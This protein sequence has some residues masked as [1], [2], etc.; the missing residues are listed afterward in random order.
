M[1]RWIRFLLLGLRSLRR[2]RLRPDEESTLTLR[3]W[4]T[5][6]DISVVNNAAYLTYFE[7]GRV[8]LQLRTGF[9]RLALRRGWSAPLGSVVVVFKRPLR[10]FQRIRLTARLAYWDDR[11]LY[12]EHRLERDRDTIA[13]AL[14]KSMILG[15]DG[16]IAPAA[17][18]SE[19]GYSLPQP[20]MPAMIEKF[21]EGEMLMQEP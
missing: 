15:K 1:S 20:P 10:R 4:P 19:L 9:T 16:R 12:I 18:I 5:D 7:M 8:D 14:S 3:V 6:A 13:T 2:P 11:W 17:A 21:R